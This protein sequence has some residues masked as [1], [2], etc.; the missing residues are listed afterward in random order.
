MICEV[1]KNGAAATD[2]RLKPGDLILQVNGLDF[3]SVIHKQAVKLLRSLTGNLVTLIIYRE[4]QQPHWFKPDITCHT[5][6]SVTKEV[7]LL[8]NN[9]SQIKLTSTNTNTEQITMGDGNVASSGEVNSLATNESN[10]VN[11]PA[12]VTSGD[13]NANSASLDASE[14]EYVEAIFAKL[15]AVEVEFHKKPGKSLGI[16]VGSRKDASNLP[17][18]TKILSGGLVESTGQ[19]QVGDHLLELNGQNL[20]SLTYP[21]VIALMKVRDFTVIFPLVNVVLVVSLFGVNTCICMRF[22][23]QDFCN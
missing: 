2:G 11:N 13:A 23:L 14:F 8:R 7:N 20:T 9:Q 5:I 3:R 19:I 16:V 21:E 15:D 17:V 12:N 18:I 4:I 1:Y 22:N 10:L 6:R